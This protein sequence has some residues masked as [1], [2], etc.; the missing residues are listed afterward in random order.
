MNDD[1]GKIGNVRDWTQAP[2]LRARVFDRN[3]AHL[4]DLGLP[5]LHLGPRTAF[6]RDITLTGRAVGQ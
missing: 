4:L 3:L 6:G 2:R 1:D 5:G